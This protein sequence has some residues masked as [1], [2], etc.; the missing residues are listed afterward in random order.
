MDEKKKPDVEPPTKKPYKKP[1]ILSRE[2]IEGR[3]AVCDPTP[4]LGGKA[5]GPSCTVVKS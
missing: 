2:K 4:G 5:T 1:R 3:A